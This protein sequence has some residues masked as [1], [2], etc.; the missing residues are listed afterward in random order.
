ML[1]VDKN[2]GDEL[3]AAEFNQIPDEL[4]KVI[5]DSGQAPS[6]ADVEQVTKAIYRLASE[7]SWYTDSGVA[8]AYV[9]TSAGG[10]TN[11]PGNFDGKLLRFT[12]NNTNTGPSTV[13]PNGDGVTPLTDIAGN[14]LIGGEMQANQESIATFISATGNY[15]LLTAAS[16]TALEVDNAITDSGQTPTAAD[17]FELSKAFSNFSGNGS[18]YGTTGTADNNYT[19]VMNGTQK[20]PTSLFD[21]LEVRFKADFTNTSN[22]T[23][24]FPTLGTIGLRLYNNDQVPAGYI[25]LN[26]H[27]TCYYDT[28]TA[29]LKLAS[30]TESIEVDNAIID[31]G[32]TPTS[33]DQFELSKAFS[34]FSGNGSY[35]N[36]T[37]IGD[38]NYT[39]VL[40]GSQKEPTQ[41]FD[42]LEVRFRADFTNTGDTNITFP[43]LGTGI[44]LLTFE[45][46][47][48]LP[49]QIR[50]GDIITAYY[51]TNLTAFRA[52][53]TGITNAQNESFSFK[54]LLIN[55]RFEVDQYN[56]ILAEDVPTTYVYDRWRLS[57]ASVGGGMTKLLGAKVGLQQGSEI[58]QIMDSPGLA[59]KTVTFS[60]LEN[61]A[62]T[63]TGQIVGTSTNSGAFQ[64]FPFTFTFGAGDTGNV[65]VVIRNNEPATALFNGAQLE[66]GNYATE[67]DYRPVN[68]D[69]A[70]CLAYFEALGYSADGVYGTGTIMF[71]LGTVNDADVLIKYRRKRIPP[72]ITLTGNVAL[73]RAKILSST[74]VPLDSLSVSTIREESAT[75]SVEFITTPTALT[76]RESFVLGSANN[77]VGILI[78]SE[79][80]SFP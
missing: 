5:T 49:G 54:N 55:P 61:T 80:T 42:G 79:I 68:I 29:T 24:T 62:G 3:T 9:L 40:N 19:L 39:L 41:L 13:N 45:G 73:Y 71:P 58:E 43:T 33:A 36:T 56:N 22:T 8:N 48:F 7:A 77:N 16:T 11:L 34:N 70:I 37:M 57:A 63:L 35:Y 69:Y 74:F 51:D 66:I 65:R 2:T 27:I 15:R 21:G 44:D 17:L 6:A 59:G 53:S 23:V 1:I 25:Q 32:Q 76:A 18:Y 28:T 30:R 67:F 75:L 14:A 78:N 12:P 60:L 4:E 10:V 52:A 72:T 26:D 38:N 20:E 31:S 64:E 47:Q 46:D 50:L